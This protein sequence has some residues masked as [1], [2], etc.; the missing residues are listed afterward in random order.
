MI[1]G[2][3]VL[4]KGEIWYISKIGRKTVCLINPITRKITR[5]SVEQVKN[6]RLLSIAANATAVRT[7]RVSDAKTSSL[8]SQSNLFLTNKE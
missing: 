8:N 2:E 5:A 7:G 3:P 6:C 4:W 1:L